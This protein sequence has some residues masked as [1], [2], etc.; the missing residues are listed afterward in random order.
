[1]LGYAELVEEVSTGS[2][3]V[4]KAWINFYYKFDYL[5]KLIHHFYIDDWRG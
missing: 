4:V 2:S 1:M 3:K 5:K